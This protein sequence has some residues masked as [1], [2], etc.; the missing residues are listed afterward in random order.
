MR[1]VKTPNLDP[2][3]YQ[4]GVGLNDWS[5]W[6][7]AYVQTAF[8]TGWAGSTAWDCWS[9]RLTKKHA[10]RNLPAGVYIPIF[11]SGYYGMGHTAIYKDGKVW[12][13]PLT[14]KPYADVFNSIGEVERSFGVVY[15]GWSEDLGGT[16]LV[17]SSAGVLTPN[18]RVVGPN[19]AN[20]RTEPNKD[21]TLI[22]EFDAG[23]VLNFKGYVRGQDPY[24]NGNNIWF[25]GAYTGGFVY[26]GACTDS[27]TNGL[28]DITPSTPEPPAQPNTKDKVIDVSAH[29]SISDYATVINN[30]R[31]AVAKAG[32]TGKSYGGTPLNGDPKFNDYKINFGAK[33]NGAYWYAYC[34]LDPITEAKAFVQ[35]VG[36]VPNNFSYWLDIEETNDQTKEQINAWCVKFLEEVDKQTGRV[37][38]IY[39]N[40]NWFDNYITQE[41]KGSR[42][43]WLAHYDTPEFSNPVLNQVAHQYTS[44]GKVTGY[45]GNL[46]LNAVKDEFFVPKP[47]VPPTIPE[48]PVV[49]ENPNPDTP[50]PEKPVEQPENGSDNL[51]SVIRSFIAKI[52]SWLSQWKRGK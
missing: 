29:N 49:P 17:E 25:V 22:K 52:I 12:S 16:L 20:Y 6:C 51:W 14:H 36:D 8:G 4:N 7:L 19:G 48:P 37:C 50:K 2:V 42:P 44:S 13:S 38:G 45:N 39:M 10:D 9:N 41:T 27:S 47:F 46:D 24:G 31:G 33:L 40:R 32:H 23:E 5:G 43:I 34:S 28:A 18:Q 1:Q 26:S 11:F 30:V 35:S 3:I 21:S 15:V